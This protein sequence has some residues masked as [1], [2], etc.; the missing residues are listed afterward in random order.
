MRVPAQLTAIA[1]LFT[2]GSALA[3]ADNAAAVRGQP[4]KVLVTWTAKGPVDLYLAEK[5]DADPA[6]AKL[7]SPG[8]RDG[9]EEVAVDGA[10]RP[11]FLIRDKADGS[12]VAVAERLLPLAQGSNFRDIGGYEGAGGKHVRWGLIYRSGAT[13]LLTDSDLTQVRALGLRN[14]VDLRSA[15][16]RVIAATRID[17]VP[18]SAVGYSMAGILE[19]SRS[20]L[21]GALYR[22]FP[23]MLAPQLRIVFNQLKRGEGPIAYNCSAGQDR[24]GFATAMI[25]AALGVPR[26]TILEDYHLST[27]YRRP[28]FEQPPIQAAAYPDNAVIQQLA[29]GQARRAGYKPR[30]LFDQDGKSLLLSAFAEVDEKYGS[31]EGY[32][33]RELG[34]SAADIG[35]LRANYLN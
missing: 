24:T 34:V 2:A 11:Y 18:Y 8:D 26:E 35:A 25:L 28:E 4:G 23:T 7:V 22:D 14:M 21:G 1:L 12:R 9:R 16:E 31:V 15:E 10:A 33:E 3:R 32:L 29:Q 5:P 17:G 27:D 6:T 13:P 20:G 19:R 30:P